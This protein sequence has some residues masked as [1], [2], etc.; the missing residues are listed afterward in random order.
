[1]ECLRQSQVAKVAL[2]DFVKLAP[3][4]RHVIAASEE[5]MNRLAAEFATIVSK[6][7]RSARDEADFVALP[8]RW[9]QFDVPF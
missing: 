3:I 5:G 6:G 7:R 2:E 1:M 9:E 8:T 4:E